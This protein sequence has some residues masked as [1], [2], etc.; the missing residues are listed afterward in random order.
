[1]S[2]GHLKKRQRSQLKSSVLHT[3]TIGE[4]TPYPASPQ[5]P[6]IL[7]LKTLVL[8]LF[9]WSI[10]YK[11]YQLRDYIKIHTAQ[12]LWTVSS[13]T[14]NYATDIGTLDNLMI[15]RATRKNKSPKSTIRVSGNSWNV[16]T[17][18]WG[19]NFYQPLK[20]SNP[21]HGH[22][23]LTAAILHQNIERGSCCTATI[24]TLTLA[25]FLK[26][27]YFNPN[28]QTIKQTTTTKQQ[29]QQKPE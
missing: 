26:P 25:S 1:M 3:K 21:K 5:Q 4:A 24:K 2:F 7:S 18:L 14:Q 15:G 8:S 6:T 11:T 19:F 27:I 17:E 23:S 12:G 9:W 29:K 10:Y 22:Q 20:Q 13:H 16:N 28:L